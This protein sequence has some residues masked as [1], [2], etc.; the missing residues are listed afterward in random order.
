MHVHPFSLL[1]I[2]V[3]RDFFH[4]EK[5]RIINYGKVIRM[6]LVVLRF[7]SVVKSL[8]NGIGSVI[9]NLLEV[10]EPSCTSVG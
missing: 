2:L 4:L 1:I 9:G 5:K 8:A 7:A 10:Y 3:S 6:T